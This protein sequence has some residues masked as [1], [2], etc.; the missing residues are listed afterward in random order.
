MQP[1]DLGAQRGLG[2]VGDGQ[3]VQ[4]PHTRQ[5]NP[6]DPTHRDQVLADASTRLT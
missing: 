6:T 3:P 2:V 5:F 4:N 1:A